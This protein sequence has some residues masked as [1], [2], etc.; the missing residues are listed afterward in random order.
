[1]LALRARP[2]VLTHLLELNVV[3]LTVLLEI[4]SQPPGG[5]ELTGG[6]DVRLCFLRRL[7]LRPDTGLQVTPRLVQAAGRH[8]VEFIAREAFRLQFHVR[9]HYSLLGPFVVDVTGA[10]SGRDRFLMQLVDVPVEPLN[11]RL[12][13]IVLQLGSGTAVSLLLVLGVG[14]RGCEAHTDR[15]VSVDLL[16]FLRRCHF[17]VQIR[18]ASVNTE[19]ILHLPRYGRLLDLLTIIS[20]QNGQKFT[21][22][23]NLREHLMDR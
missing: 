23:L 18:E 3:L 4:V 10:L 19:P 2:L 15:Y 16:L 22:Y 20:L 21:T 8:V 1:M 5:V 7:A 6:G 14:L 9:A 17:D 11:I 12:E 13:R